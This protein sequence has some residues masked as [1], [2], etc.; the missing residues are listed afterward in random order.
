MRPSSRVIQRRCFAPAQAR[1]D[2]ALARLEHAVERCAGTGR[3]SGRSSTGPARTPAA[4]CSAC[5]LFSTSAHGVVTTSSTASE[6]LTPTR[7]T[8]IAALH[9][10]VAETPSWTGPSA[11][12]NSRGPG[13]KKIDGMT[14]MPAKNGMPSQTRLTKKSNGSRLARAAARI[15]AYSP[16]STPSDVEALAARPRRGTSRLWRADRCTAASQAGAQDPLGKPRARSRQPRQRRCARASQYGPRHGSF[17]SSAIPHAGWS[18]QPRRF[19][20]R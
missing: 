7:V 13:T 12:S 2:P 11:R 10:P 15:T 5:R 17:G 3:C 18:G 4:P 19:C 20:A 1:H 8:K 14:T 6:T 16:I 9:T